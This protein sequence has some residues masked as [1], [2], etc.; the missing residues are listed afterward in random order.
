MLCP[1][2]QQA[3]ILTHQVVLRFQFIFGQA[4]SSE[5]SSLQLL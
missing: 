2:K 1:I 3:F 4:Y 5:N